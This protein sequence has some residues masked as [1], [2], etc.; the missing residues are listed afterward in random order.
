M[1]RNLY[2][3]PVRSIWEFDSF[4]ENDGKIFNFLYILTLS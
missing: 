2:N 1:G 4:V 3:S